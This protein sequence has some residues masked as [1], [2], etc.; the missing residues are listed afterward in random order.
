MTNI[1]KKNIQTILG[2]LNSF[3][4][5]REERKIYL[6]GVFATLETFGILTPSEAQEMFCDCF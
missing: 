1:A 3:Y 6:Q 4:E 5:D 2:N